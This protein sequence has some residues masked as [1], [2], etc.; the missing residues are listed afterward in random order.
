MNEFDT[1]FYRI[2]GRKLRELRTQ[3]DY[4]LEFLADK[5]G[6]T[7]K[8]VQRYEVG[9]RKIDAKKLRLMVES[10]GGDY[11]QFIDS[12]QMEQSGLKK[13][14]PVPESGHSDVA[15]KFADEFS[16][17][18]PEEWAKLYEYAELLKTARRTK[19]QT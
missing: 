6:A 8:T 15:I 18:G 16:D 5:I 19:E 7:I 17:F 4:T 11:D 13:P 12:V 2:V 1:V 9:E 3:N 14:T 10:L